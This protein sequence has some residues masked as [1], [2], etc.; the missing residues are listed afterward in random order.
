MLSMFEECRSAQG[1]WR[2]L[3]DVL[4][5][6][7][8][9]KVH[10]LSTPAPKAAP[11]Y[12]EIAS[13]PCLARILVAAVCGVVLITG[14]LT[15]AKPK[16]PESW[17]MVRSEVRFWFPTGI[18]VVGRKPNAP[19]SWRVLRLEDRVRLAKCSDQLE[20]TFKPT[21]TFSERAADHPSISRVA[22]IRRDD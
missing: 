13:S 4:L 2:V 11:L 19:E 18:V 17:T 15:G 22:E 21:S 3:A 5:S 10:Y 6:A 14:V 12:S 20:N 8:K 9:Q 7:L 1:S 16:A